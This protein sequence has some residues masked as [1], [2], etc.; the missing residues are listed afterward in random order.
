L[1]GELNAQC[2]TIVIVTHEERVARAVGR[3]VRI[4]GG[5]A[6]DEARPA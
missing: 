1:F 2:T 6:V 4:A 5:V 3:V